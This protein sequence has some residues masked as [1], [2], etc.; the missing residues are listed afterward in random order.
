MSSKRNKKI[1]NITLI[2]V[3]TAIASIIYMVFPEINIIPGV[4]YM[5]I[6]F[7]DF[8]AILTGIVFGPWQGVMIMLIKNVIHLTKTTTIGI[9]EIMNFIIG[10]GMVISM[11]CFTRLFSKL[12]R[13]KKFSVKAYGL[14]A[15]ITVAV[16]ILLGWTTNM[17]FTPVFFKLMGI[18]LVKSAYWAGVWGSTALNTVKAVFNILPFYPIYLSVEK[19]IKKYNI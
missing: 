7:S 11:S 1:F 16:T 8:P 19:A 17:I 12:F 14:T 18:P 10:S 6:D 5:K 4:N 13:E 3:M 15:I 9:G 2:A